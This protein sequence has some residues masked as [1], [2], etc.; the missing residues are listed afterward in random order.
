MKTL[1]RRKDDSIP[2]GAYIMLEEYNDDNI[3]LENLR[4]RPSTRKRETGFF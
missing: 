1:Q 3:V 2:F 4:F